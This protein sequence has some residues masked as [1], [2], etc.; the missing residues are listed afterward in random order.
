MLSLC[1]SAKCC[2][3]APAL[4]P[5]SVHRWRPLRLCVAPLGPRVPARVPLFCA[6]AVRPG[7]PAPSSS[8]WG[9]F[10]LGSPW[11][12]LRGGLPRGSRSRVYFRLRFAARPSVRASAP[13]LR[14]FL[15]VLPRRVRARFA[16]RPR[17]LVN[18]DHGKENENTKGPHRQGFPSALR[19]L[20]CE[21]LLRLTRDQVGGALRSAE[22]PPT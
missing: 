18:Q 19:A 14:P 13:R 16:A 12:A 15:A 6:A 20:D 3:S 17:R 9:P 7:A 22:D 4:R 2:A 8:P 21:C 11:L 1:A 5:P 10:P